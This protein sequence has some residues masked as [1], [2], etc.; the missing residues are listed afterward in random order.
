[1]LFQ[2]DRGMSK[3]ILKTIMKYFKTVYS[4]NLWNNSESVSGE[5]STIK[6][7]GPYILFLQNFVKEKSIKSILDLGCGDF[8]LMRHF[9]FT[10]INYLGIDLIEPL[11]DK[12]NQTYKSNNIR[13]E[14]GI[15]HDYGFTDHYD[16][17]L[18][19][20]VL[21]HW[22][23]HSVQQFLK[24]LKNYNY[25]I[26]TNDYSNNNYNNKTHNVNILDS[27]YTVVDL[28]AEPYN[29]KGD[30]IFEWNACGVLKRSFLLKTE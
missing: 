15:I 1:M 7:S 10:G 8:N 26:L 24:L 21:Q 28:T 5:G 6:C 14:C 22:S 30:C 16:L 23:N 29:L 18:C 20:D 12:N 27:E 3:Y 17:I 2:L 11:I 25:S 19:K 4:E 9:D 13:F